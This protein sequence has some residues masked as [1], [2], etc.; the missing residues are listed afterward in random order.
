M[1]FIADA[2]SSVVN[3]VGDVVETAVDFVGN[4]VE[5]VVDVLSD[6]FDDP[7]KTALTAAAIYTGY[8]AWTAPATGATI[9]GGVAGAGAAPGTYAALSGP[10]FN[11]ALATAATSTATATAGIAAG[12]A[13]GGQAFSFVPGATAGWNMTGS[14]LS[15][16][17]N[18]FAGVG[19]GSAAGSM[20]GSVWGVSTPTFMEQAGERID[21]ITGGFEDI[22]ESPDPVGEVWEKI[23]DVGE[24]AA[25]EIGYK[26]FLK[27][28]AKETLMANGEQSLLGAWSPTIGYQAGGDPGSATAQAYP[29][30]TR[31]ETGIFGDPFNLEG[32]DVGLTVNQLAS[33]LQQQQPTTFPLPAQA[34]AFRGG[35]LPAEQQR[36][37]MD[38]NYNASQ[39]QQPMLEAL[40]AQLGAGAQRRGLETTSAGLAAGIAPLMEQFQRNRLSDLQAGAGLDLEA[41]GQGVT[42]RGQDIQA[43]LGQ[44]DV[45]TAAD[46]ARKNI[47]LNSL[48]ALA[49][50]SKPQ[51]VG[52]T[53]SFS[54]TQGATRPDIGFSGQVPVG[55]IMDAGWNLLAGKGN[56]PG[57]VSQAAGWVDD[58]LLGDLFGDWNW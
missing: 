56:Q 23:G 53:T 43:L 19:A 33:Q 55:G 25:E 22:I 57:L 16:A 8:N 5:S 32:R 54:D 50:M 31:A 46:V 26:P 39:V 58:T 44:Q 37:L 11:P 36:A 18:T 3:F 48:L 28:V 7:F 17:P 24:Y 10:M 40:T 35:G 27:N 45:G 38:P 41:R 52:G 20:A 14:S 49:Q 6:P 9:G 47:T 34:G 29:S 1:G 4:A 12:V 2:V 15:L 13:A 30:F 42:G 21:K 51:I